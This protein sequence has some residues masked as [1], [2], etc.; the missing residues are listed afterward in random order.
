MEISSIDILVKVFIFICNG[1]YLEIVNI[2][3][4]LPNSGEVLKLMI[5]SCGRK[6][7]S[8]P[9]NSRCKVISHKIFEK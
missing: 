1:V 9:T 6:V 7:I 3:G 2:W 8:G 4:K 5:P